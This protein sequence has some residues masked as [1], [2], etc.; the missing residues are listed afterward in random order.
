[1]SDCPF[2]NIGEVDSLAQHFLGSPLLGGVYVVW[3]VAEPGK[4]YAAKAAD[5]KRRADDVQDQLRLASH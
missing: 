1:M 4:G 3:Y 5:W 2:L